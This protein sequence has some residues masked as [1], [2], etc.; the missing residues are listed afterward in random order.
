MQFLLKEIIEFVTFFILLTILLYYLVEIS[1]S[2]AVIMALVIW[3]ISSAF[4][5][6]LKTI[7]K[8]IKRC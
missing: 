5:F 3:A 8:R 1:F 4:N 2:K 7:A 6:I